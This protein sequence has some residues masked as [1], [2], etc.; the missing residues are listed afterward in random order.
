MSLHVHR[1]ARPEGLEHSGWEKAPGK[2]D[3]T[4][5]DLVVPSTL[6][7]SAM[8]ASGGSQQRSDIT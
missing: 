4:G 5:E 2:Q 7:L 6:S 3:Q 1:P 8:G